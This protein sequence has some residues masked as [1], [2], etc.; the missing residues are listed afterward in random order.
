MLVFIKFEDIATILCMPVEFIACMMVPTPSLTPQI[1][2]INHTLTSNGA[3][4][5]P[6]GAGG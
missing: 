2:I 3:H 6:H 5:A 4:D 1:R